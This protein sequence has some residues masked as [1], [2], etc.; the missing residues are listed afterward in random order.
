MGFTEKTG[1]CK[2][3]RQQRIIKVPESIED[4]EEL[5]KIATQ[6]CS[7]PEAR[8]EQKKEMKKEAAGGY[9]E[10]I[11]DRNEEAKRVLKMAVEAVY[12]GR[13]SRVTLSTGKHTY[14]VEQDGKGDIH[15][16]RSFTEKTDESF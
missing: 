15:I 4:Q 8:E 10:N 5:D 16:K 3:C 1:M 13:A 2:F 12:N 9:I 14:A 11:L 6:E 7:C